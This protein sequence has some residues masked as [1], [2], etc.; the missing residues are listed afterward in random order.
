MDWIQW[1][2]KGGGV[3]T[4][5]QLPKSVVELEEMI[6]KFDS[7]ENAHGEKQTPVV[8]S[9]KPCATHHD[10]PETDTSE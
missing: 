6:K 3:V 4:G 7:Q 8:G 9:W 5:H 1:S 10:R 2:S